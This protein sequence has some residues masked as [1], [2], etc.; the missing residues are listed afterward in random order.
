MCATNEY[1]ES[2]KLRALCLSPFT[3]QRDATLHPRLINTQAGAFE[4]INQA[5]TRPVQALERLF[6]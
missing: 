4:T 1:A 2:C 6:A 5:F 3:P